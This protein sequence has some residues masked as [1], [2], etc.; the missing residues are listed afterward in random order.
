VDRVGGVVRAPPGCG[1]LVAAGIAAAGVATGATGRLNRW[2]AIPVSLP[3]TA[4]A[5]AATLAAAIDTIVLSALLAAA[6]S[7]SRLILATS[8]ARAVLAR[9]R[10]LD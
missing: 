9:R 4:V 5:T 7:S 1:Q 6:A 8:E 3:A 10:M 2:I